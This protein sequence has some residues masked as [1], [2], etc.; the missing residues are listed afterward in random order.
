M[1]S[2]STSGAQSA[3]ASEADELSGGSS[4]SS[5]RGSRCYQSALLQR[6]SLCT[7]AL[8]D[9]CFSTER[10]G[11]EVEL[12]STIRESRD[13]LSHRLKRVQHDCPGT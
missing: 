2:S 10:R 7:S 9:R 4:Q 11:G 1:S 8:T 3:K 12:I 13:K 5:P 6:R